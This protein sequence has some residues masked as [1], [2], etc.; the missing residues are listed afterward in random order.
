MWYALRI[1]PRAD[2]DFASSAADLL[3]STS[4]SLIVATGAAFLIWY[5][6]IVIS[7]PAR[8]IIADPIAL[9]VIV[10]SVLAIW[11]GS[12]RFLA[13][14]A[15][16]QV[17][18][19]GAIAL[20]LHIFQLPEIAFLYMLLPL[21]AVVSVGWPFGLFSEGLVIALVLWFP[22][23][24]LIPPLSTSYVLAIAISGVFSGLLGWAATRTL[25]TVTQWSLFSYEEARKKMED[26]RTHRMELKQTQ[27]DLV[28]ANR[29]LARLSDR[30]KVMYQVA[31]EARQ[32]KAEFVANV[33][34]ELRTP[35]NMI[36]GFSEVITQSPEVYG[37]ALPAAL[38]ADITA[39]QRNS[40]HLAGLVDDVLDLSQIEAGRMAVSK[41]WNSLQDIIE[42]AALAVR[43]L[44]DT[45]GLYLETDVLSDLPFVFCDGT[46][47]RQV[48]I[49]LLSNAG[50]FTEHGGVRIRVWRE[51]ED[52]MISVADTGPGIPSEEQ[53]KLFEPFQQADSSIRRRYGGS[54]L[55]LSISKRFVEMHGG[56]MWL[57]SEVGVGTTITFS[58][59]Q[60]QMP[61]LEPLSGEGAIRWFS[62]Y[63]DYEYRARTRP[64]R[65]PAPRLNPRY[66][67]LEKGDTLQRLFAR[68]LD[69]VE[70]V[71][72]RDIEEATSELSRLP[73]QALIVNTPPCDKSLITPAYPVGLPFGTPVVTCWV[74]GEDEAMAKLGVV[75]YLVKP[76]TRDSLLI[77]LESLG[78]HVKNVLLVDDEREILRLF[79]R[80]LSTSAHRYSITWATSG[81]RALDLLRERQPDV[82][83]LDLVMPGID[84]FQVLEEKSRDSAIREIPVVV[85]SSRDPKGEPIIS[86]VLTVSR[87]GGLSAHDLLAS[88]QAITQILSPAGVQPA[89]L[90]GPG[91]S[92]TP[93]A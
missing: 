23:T 93:G 62:P 61:R 79:S 50:R 30:L 80:M 6:I 16:W 66:V 4:R 89:Q 77:A 1:S 17:G 25:L 72:V 27:E 56:R 35:L 57:E 67:L 8:M 60:L 87:G 63:S 58:L 47:I 3:R 73:A 41:E 24:L 15:L 7:W 86:D 69:G 2:P 22:H 29:E 20:A 32:A 5:T 82:I 54:G 55:G 33:S 26:A 49:N 92:E 74:P 46:R 44:F 68:C 43:A 78:E 48:V 38:L 13:A 39:I 88:V 64:S 28:Q 40:Q 71:A 59:P 90:G 75:R 10:T 9:T 83:L 12:K 52:A 21:T 51:N 11:L 34:H 45:K 14:Q 37:D 91:Q 84:G 70:T 42:N 18:I 36:I 19:A 81:Q 85:V 31:E 53:E 76:V 65:A